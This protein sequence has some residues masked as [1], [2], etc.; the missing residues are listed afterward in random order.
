M[1]LCHLILKVTHLN[2]LVTAVKIFVIYLFQIH[3]LDMI[4]LLWFYTQLNLNNVFY[5]ES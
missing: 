4:I 5:T 2:N 1:Q 3:Q